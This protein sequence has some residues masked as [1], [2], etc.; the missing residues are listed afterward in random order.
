MLH[1]NLFVLKWQKQQPYKGRHSL[2]Y[3]HIGRLGGS[4]KGWVL[5]PFSNLIKLY[6]CLNQTLTK[7]LSD[8][9]TLYQK[10]STYFG[11]SFEE[12]VARKNPERARFFGIKLASSKSKP[13]EHTCSQILFV[14]LPWNL[15]KEKSMHIICLLRQNRTPAWETHQRSL[16]LSKSHRWSRSVPSF[17]CFLLTI[18][19]SPIS[20]KIHSAHQLPAC[21]FACLLAGEARS[22]LSRE[23]DTDSAAA[24]GNGICPSC[25]AMPSSGHAKQWIDGE[26]HGGADW[27]IT[28]LKL[29]HIQTHMAPFIPIKMWSA[30]RFAFWIGSNP[31]TLFEIMPDHF[32]SNYCADEHE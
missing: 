23:G 22:I 24:A 10:Q 5:F 12:R 8:Q 27:Y 6:L 9:K 25:A 31:I 2:L 3:V 30:S 7:V 32:C 21:L 19:S 17:C 13:N 26:Q 14:V 11:I 29:P 18:P 16:Q 20:M 15:Y 28:F 1:R 4:A